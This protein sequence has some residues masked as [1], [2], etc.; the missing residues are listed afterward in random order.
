M[1]FHTVEPGVQG[2]ACSLGVVPYQFF[3]FQ[4]GQ[5]TGYRWLYQF[6]H[7]RPGFNEGLGLHR[8]QRRRAHRRTTVRLQRVVGHP[9]HVP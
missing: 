1:D 9:P 5:G 7:T 2:I 3:D 8:R 4:R 6:T